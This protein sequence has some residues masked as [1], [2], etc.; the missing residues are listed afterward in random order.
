M[1][2]AES[3]DCFLLAAPDESDVLFELHES[4]L[5]LPDAFSG[6]SKT[7]MFSPK[8]YRDVFTGGPEK[9]SGRNNADA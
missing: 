9:A 2:D 5:F 6:L 4:A 8:P 3:R 1:Q 7:G